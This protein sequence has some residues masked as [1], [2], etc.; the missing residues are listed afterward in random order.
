MTIAAVNAQ[1]SVVISGV[2]EA[3]VEIAGQVEG[4]STRLRVSHAFH[5]PLMDPML[6]EFQAVAAKISFGVPGIALVSTV[7]GEL[8]GPEEMTEA[9]YWAGQVRGTVRFADSV[10]TLRA[11][12]V[13]TLVEVGPKPALTPLIGDAVPTQRKDDAETA[14]LLRALGT[15]HTQGHDITWETTFTH[16]APQTVDLPTYAFQHKRYWIDAV[17]SSGDPTGLGQRPADHPLLGAALALPGMDGVVLTGRLAADSQSWLPDHR[18]LG[19]TILPGTALLDMAVHAGEQVGYPVVDEL[20]LEAPLPVPD[21]EVLDLQVIVGAANE[22]GHRSVEIHSRLA[23]LGAAAGAGPREGWTRHAV[24]LVAQADA[25]SADEIPAVDTEVWPPEGATPLATDSMYEG[26]AALGYDYGP[27]FR[28]VR[29]VWQHGDDIYGEIALPDEAVGAE[30]FG[31]HPALLDAAL[32]LIDFMPGSGKAEGEEEE[33][34]IPFAWSGVDFHTPGARLLRVR[35]SAA[36]A[37]GVSLA[38]VDGAGTP[39][40]SIASLALRPVTPQQLGAGP[41]S[42]YRMEW[43]AVPADSPASAE[44]VEP[45]ELSEVLG[46]PETAAVPALVVLRPDTETSS[47]VDVPTRVGRAA[48][49]VLDALRTWLAEERF[50]SS[51]LVVVT[52]GAVRTGSDDGA[53]DLAQAPVWGLVRAAQAENPGRFTVIDVDGSAGSDRALAAAAATEEPELAL[54]GGRI[55]APRLARAGAAGGVP[56]WDPS[57]TV[58]VTGGTGGLGALVARHLV[59]AHGVRHLV[60]TSRRGNEAPGAAELTAELTELGAHV[61]VAACDVA[62]RDAVAAVLDAIPDTHPLTGVVHSAGV[63]D[64]GILAD[65]NPERVERVLRPKVDGAWHLHELTRDLDLTAFVLFSSVGGLILAAGQA[66]YAAANVFLDALAHHRHTQGLPATS[67][68]WGLWEGTAGA[69]EDTRAIDAGRIGKLGV[70]ELSAEK[71]LGLFDAALASGEAMPVPVSLDLAALRSRPDA[72]PAVLRELGGVPARPKADAP[73]PAAGTAAAEEDTRPLAERLAELPWADAG[74]FLVELVR[75]HVAAVLGHDGPQAVVPER[76]FLELGLDSL[77]ALE[78]RNR[79]SGATGERLPATLI[80]DYPSTVAVADFLRT[81]IL[82]EEPA[83]GAVTAMEEELARLESVMLDARPD[84]AE[85]ARIES[86]LRALV[87]KWSETHRGVDSSEA[88]AL[89]AATADELFDMLDD[90]LKDR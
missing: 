66:N 86:R 36:G 88:D 31:V 54:R 15:L 44:A 17:P 43:T 10:A 79:L 58:L 78:L 81:E 72:L 73:A 14:N 18:I 89:A 39:V 60:L 83:A 69:D 45:V 42:L 19:A 13:T 84:D 30:S 32:H 63:M 27:Q 52:H 4:K 40:A 59:T 8:V 75:T 24:G 51:R 25:S 74:Q 76:G 12:G 80:Y 28:G 2:E 47:D 11:Q 16:L 64:N 67:M 48:V 6:G 9:G 29:A 46:A 5:S 35:M 68:A 71:G 23:S 77:A 57:G 3:V 65:Q 38:I 34:R 70:R 82:G 37:G 21:E 85:A 62:D 55:L 49:S 56:E 61:T 7:T 50:H 41:Q 87:G 1:R 33:T 26:L 22:S 90:E 20:T 53:P